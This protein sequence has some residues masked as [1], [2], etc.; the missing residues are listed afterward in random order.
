MF[1]WPPTPFRRRRN[2]SPAPGRRPQGAILPPSS[3]IPVLT[4]EQA[5]A[6]IV[7][8]YRRLQWAYLFELFGPSY[9]FEHLLSLHRSINALECRNPWLKQGYFLP[10]RIENRRRL[11]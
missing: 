10:A 6:P 8:E 1:L 7:N 11:Q 3:E 2:L 9:D 5:K 4:P